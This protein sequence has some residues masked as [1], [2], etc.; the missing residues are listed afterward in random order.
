[1]NS[2]FVKTII[3]GMAALETRLLLL[4]AVSL[5]APVNGYQLRRELMSWEVD[6]WANIAPGT[7]YNGLATLTKRGELVRHDVRD[8][9]RTVAVYEVSE[10]GRAEF[11]R[12]LESAMTTVNITAPIAFHTAMSLLPLVPRAEARRLIAMRLHLLDEA[13]QQYAQAGPGLDHAPPH[14]AALV[15]FWERLAKT[16][17]EW[18]TR[19]AF[20]IAD[21]ALDFAGDPPSWTPADNDPGWQLAA[22]RQRYLDLLGRHS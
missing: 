12:L 7:I 22:D 20:R 13:R 6:R 3:W 2:L 21:G 11:A 5:F 18:L 14:V 8:D 17:N 15:D 4:G 16:E 9:D 10:A 1:M 19:L